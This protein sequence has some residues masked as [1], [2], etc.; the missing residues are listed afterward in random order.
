MVA[1]VRASGYLKENFTPWTLDLGYLLPEELLLVATGS[2]G[3]TGAAAET[4]SRGHPD[5]NLSAGDHVIFSTMT[6]PG[7]EQQVNA[8]VAA[9]RAR[10][11]TV[12]LA[13]ESDIPL[14]LRHPCAAVGPDVSVD[15]PHLAIPVHGEDST[16][17]PMPGWPEQ[18]VPHQLVGRNGDLFDLAENP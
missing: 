18:G 6:I 16:C 8:L 13:D 12:T 17:G 7:N 9:F 14:H 10:G 5:V 15:R 2:Q 3:E 11:I 1:S 4:G